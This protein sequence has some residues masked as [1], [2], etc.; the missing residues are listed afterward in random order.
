M[1]EI[2]LRQGADETPDDTRDPAAE[3]DMAT[4]PSDV[5]APEADAVEQRLVASP[6][7]NPLVTD[8][9][10]ANRDAVIGAGDPADLLEQAEVVPFDEDEYR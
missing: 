8:L 5:E 1:S 4:P 6:P 3:E 7:A 2:D 9:D 10:R